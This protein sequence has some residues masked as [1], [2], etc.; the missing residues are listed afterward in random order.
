MQTV[1]VQVKCELGNVYSVAEKAIETVE[2]ISEIYSTSGQ[3][4]LLI[5]CYLSDGDDIGHFIND[6]IQTL[7]GVKDTY[8][9]ITFKAFS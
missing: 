8:T 2:K 3:Y 7:S 5:K 4:D 6:K 1:F 9:L